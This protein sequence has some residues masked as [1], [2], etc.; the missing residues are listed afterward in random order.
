MRNF[1]RGQLARIAGEELWL[2]FPQVFL[3]SNPLMFMCKVFAFFSKT[4][5]VAERSKALMMR[6]DVS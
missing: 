3:K 1:W 6:E 5:R 2:A 4:D